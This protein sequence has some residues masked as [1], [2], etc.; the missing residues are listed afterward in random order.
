MAGGGRRVGLIIILLALVIIIIL[1]VVGFFARDLIFSRFSGQ[2]SQVVATAE[3]PQTYV[4][5][6]VL[7]Q[8][9]TRGTQITEG[10]LAMVSYPQSEMVEGLF[11]TDI[12]DV[13]DKRAKYDLKQGI[14]LTPNLLMEDAG[15]SYASLQIPKGMV[16]ISLPLS[17]LTSVAY[18]LQ[19]GDHIN[20]IASLLMVDIDTDFQTISPNYTASITAPGVS[21]EGTTTSTASISSGGDASKIGKA[22]FDTSLNLPFYAVPSE[23]QRSRLISQS[24]INDAVV[25][26]VGNFKATQDIAGEQTQEQTQAVEETTEVVTPDIISI[27]VSPQDAV[28]LNYL[29]LMEAK[30]NIALRGYD[31]TDI[32]STESV[33]LQYILEHYNIPYPTKLPYGS[34]PRIDYLEYPPLRDGD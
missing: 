8:P 7:A 31:D 18:A 33:T 4:K 27:I 13:I 1:A 15:G 11:Y 21:E 20:I 3:A 23:G 14:P 25:L 29:M 26:W 34:E 17:R 10:V 6:V 12:N 22:L 5:I 32:L 19:P 28:S 9:V 2:E 16:A 30:F 24:I